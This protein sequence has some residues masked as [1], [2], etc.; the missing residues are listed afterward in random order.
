[1]KSFSAVAFV[2]L[3]EGERETFRSCLRTECDNGKGLICKSYPEENESVLE[4]SEFFE[5]PYRYGRF[6]HEFEGTY[7]VDLS[8]YLRHCS[9]ISLTKLRKYIDD[10]R[11]IRFILYAC[12]EDGDTA[13]LE[14][15]IEKCFRS[16][17]RGI[18]FYSFDSG[19]ISP[20]HRME[21]K[22]A[23]NFGY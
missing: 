21:Q 4:F 17:E 14:R 12:E 19:K 11:S 23:K 8:G 16:S 22:R 13:S 10:N 9:S 2:S 1:M 7:A 5:T 20:R 15:G 6:S 3:S 18:V